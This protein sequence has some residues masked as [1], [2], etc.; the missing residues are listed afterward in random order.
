MANVLIC[1]DLH[2]GHK[3][4]A[5]QRGLASEAANEEMLRD[6]WHNKVG[7]N[8]KVFVL[9]DVCFDAASWERFSTWSGHKVVILGN[10]CTERNSHLEIPNNIQL[11]GAMRYKEFW[12]THIPIH[13]SELRGKLNIHGHTHDIVVPDCRYYGVSV[14]QIGYSPI[15]LD[16][17][18]AE[19]KRRREFKYNVRKFG[20]VEATRA[21]IRQH[22]KPP[23]KYVR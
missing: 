15:S 14:E 13:S 8:D 16:E 4:I 6:N 21:F 20:I 2:L 17:I 12:L 22:A 3:N 18:R 5:K 23:A 19:V 7:K 11:H 9:G 10:H 1:A